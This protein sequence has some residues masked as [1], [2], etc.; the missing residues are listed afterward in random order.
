MIRWERDGSFVWYHWWQDD[1]GFEDEQG[2]D[3]GGRSRASTREPGEK[4]VEGPLGMSG[5]TMQTTSEPE[6]VP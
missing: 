5:R 3:L 4:R 2:G 1:S 6:T